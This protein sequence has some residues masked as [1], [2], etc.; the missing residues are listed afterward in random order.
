MDWEDPRHPR[1][2]LRYKHLDPRTL[3]ACESLKDTVARFLPFWNEVVAPAV[4]GGK[5]ILIVAHGNSLRALCNM[6]VVSGTN[7]G[8]E[9]PTVFFDDELD[10]IWRSRNNIG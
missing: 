2:D 5:R 10:S 4:K 1:F 7:Y 6:D 8:S 9:I 3:P